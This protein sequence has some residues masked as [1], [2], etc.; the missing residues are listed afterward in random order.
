VREIRRES[1]GRNDHTFNRFSSPI[2]ASADPRNASTS[3]V[4][5]PTCSENTNEKD[6]EEKQIADEYLTQIPD[7]AS[8][9]IQP[10][11]P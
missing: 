7:D 3:S 9:Q 8:E 6:C 5:R 2:S 1:D 4:H 10:K 11:Y